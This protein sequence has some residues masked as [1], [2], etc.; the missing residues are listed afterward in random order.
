MLRSLVGSEMCIR[1]S[2]LPAPSHAADSP[3]LCCWFLKYGEC[4]PPRPPCR[5]VHSPDD[6]HTPCCFGATCRLGHRKRAWKTLLG[7]GDSKNQ[8]AA[9]KEHWAAKHAADA[10]VGENAAGRDATALRSQLEPHSTATLRRRLVQEF[11]FNHSVLDPVG[12]AEL[13]RQLLECYEQRPRVRVRVDG[14][15]VRAELLEQIL[16]ELVKWRHGHKANTRP[17]ICAESYMIIQKPEESVKTCHSHK[18]RQATAIA[19]GP[20]LAILIVIISIII[21]TITI[22]IIATILVMVIAAHVL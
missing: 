12:R 18:A 5:F 9:M 6:G 3:G 22:V 11:G 10:R 8:E 1:D 14:T 20:F 16:E 13:M 21:G 19:G 7:D 15:P 17:S 4:V 2:F